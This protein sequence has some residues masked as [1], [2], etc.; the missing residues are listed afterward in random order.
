MITRVISEL[1]FCK[2]ELSYIIAFH[3][4]DGIRILKRRTEVDDKFSLLEILRSQKIAVGSVDLYCCTNKLP[5]CL[6]HEQ[7]FVLSLAY[8]YRI[9]RFGSIT[10][11]CDQYSNYYGDEGLHRVFLLGTT[12]A[13]HMPAKEMAKLKAFR[14]F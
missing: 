10:C 8:Y 2:L 9:F 6:I 5:M 4:A 13:N 12:Y 11:C 3:N 7:T 14:P 1:S